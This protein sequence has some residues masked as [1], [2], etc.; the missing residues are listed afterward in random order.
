[1]GYRMINTAKIWG[2]N[3]PG[4]GIQTKRHRSKVTEN[5]RNIPSQTR[6]NGKTNEGGAQTNPGGKQS[7]QESRPS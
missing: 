4:K 3:D 5:G 7:E 1:M 6:G 2:E